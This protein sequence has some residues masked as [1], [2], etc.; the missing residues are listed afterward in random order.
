MIKVRGIELGNVFTASGARGFFGEGYWH[1]HIF[2]WLLPGFDFYGS[3]FIA[4]TVTMHERM[5]N[6]DERGGNMGN[7]PLNHKTLKPIEWIP[8]CIH[9]SLLEGEVLNAVGLTGLK[10]EDMF[11]LG[12]WQHI[13]KTFGISF[14]ALGITREDRLEE[15]LDFYRIFKEYLPGFS[16]PV[17]LQINKSCPNT[18]HNPAKLTED[19]VGELEVINGLDIPIGI[20]INVLTP[21]KS[22]KEVADSGLCDFIEIP[23]TLPY[24][25]SSSICWM[26]KYGAKSP[27]RKY[28]GGG[29]S[30]PENF[31][32]AI[33]WIWELRQRGIKIPIICGGVSCKDD[34]ELANIAGA[35]AVAFARITMSPFHAWKIKG[36][37][38]YANEIFG[39]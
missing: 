36:I 27:L 17:F 33:E 21:I 10:A 37:I 16:A 35:N 38:K 4:K 22:I 34:V 15:T 1:H 8:D 26:K 18:S 32:L 20:K 39:G 5:P 3:T 12:Q 13:G 29:Y 30:G 19:I 7:L 28:G 31:R 24:G 11:R 23:N 14:M 2:Q 25:K 6:M 9:V